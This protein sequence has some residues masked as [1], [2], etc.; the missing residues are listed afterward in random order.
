MPMRTMHVVNRQV[1]NVANLERV[2][3][4]TGGKAYYN[5]NGMEQVIGEVVHNGS[6]YY[7]LAYATTNQEWHGQFRKIKVEVNR[8]GVH[9]QYRDGY[10]A[11]D[12]GQREAQKIDALK[13]ETA[14]RAAAGEKEDLEAE[15]ASSSAP[16]AQ[17]DA[18][19][20]ASDKD[21]TVVHHAA[22]GG[23]DSAMA[24]G[25]IAPTEI[26][27]QASVNSGTQPEQLARGSVQPKTNFLKSEW[28]HKPFR[29]YAVAIHADAR[30]LRLTRTA[31]G[32]LH[33]SVDFVAVVYQQTGEQV[34]SIS[35]TA[36]FDLTLG[37]YRTLLAKGLDQKLEIAVPVKGNFFLRLGVHDMVGDQVGA[38]EIPVDQV[39][40]NQP[41]SGL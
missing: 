28:Q 6:N 32:I 5:T 12:P 29:T 33:G 41:A 38:L 9:L 8:P 10:H 3:E 11:Y 37:Q 4:M 25:A 31:E 19:A 13:R 23:F 17:P 1:A 27:F 14:A 21:E 2:A 40:L 30:P 16:G 18:P 15:G 34:N 24:L 22:K 39:K 26:V 20:S 7:T 35:I 36:S